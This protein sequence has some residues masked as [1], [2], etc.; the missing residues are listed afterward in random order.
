MKV[1]ISCLRKGKKSYFGTTNWYKKSSK[2]IRKGVIRCRKSKMTD[3]I[4][5]KRKGQTMIYK[6]LHRKHKIEQH[7]PHEK[8]G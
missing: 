5:T 1:Q 7:E 6:T 4:M 3:N 8:L 2:I